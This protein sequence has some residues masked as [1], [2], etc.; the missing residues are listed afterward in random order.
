M[1]QIFFNFEQNIQVFLEFPA[2]KSNYIRLASQTP[3]YFE[4]S[5]L[6]TFISDSSTSILHLCF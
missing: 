4:K 2:F 1:S 3:F 6:F 5:Y